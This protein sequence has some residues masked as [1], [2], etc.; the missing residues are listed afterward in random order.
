[1]AS[2][3]RTLA[4]LAFAG[5][6][7]LAAEPTL[8][9]ADYRTVA[10]AVTA[11]VRPTS[12]S[13]Q[14]GYLG[15]F[16][17]R[18][19]KGR[20]AVEAVQP[21]SPAD[22]AGL[23][24]G[25]V[26]TRVGDQPVKT[27][28]AF[29]EWL[30][31]RGA[32]ESVKLGVTRDDQPVEVTA[33]LAAT[34]RPMRLGTQQVV[35][36]AELADGKEGEGAKVERVIP[37]L[38]AAKAGLKA[39][40]HIIKL[41]GDDF[42]RTGRLA[43]LLYEK[44]PG[45][46][47]TVVVRR[48]DKEVELKVTLAYERTE[49]GPGGGRGRGGFIRAGGGEPPATPWKKDVFRLAVVPIEFTDIKHSAK[50]PTKEWEDALFSRDTYRK[51][52]SATGQPVHGSLNDYF[53]EQSGG[54]FRIEGKVFEWVAVGKKRADYSQGSGVTN[55]TAVMVEALDK[56]AAR[57]TKEAVKGFDGF[58]FLYAGDRVQTNAGA[59]YYPH[60]G[61]LGWQNN[62]YFYVLGPEGGPRMASIGVF[63]K[64]VARML[65][66]PDL[67]AQR[68]NAGS[69][70]LGVWCAL[71]DTFTNGRP[72]HLSAWAKEKMGW[73]KPAVIDPTVKQKLILAPIEDS[74]KECFKVLVRPDGSEYFLLENRKK[75]GFDA[76]LP[77]EGL[78]IW[79]VVND[80]PIL[81]ESHGVE[82]PTGPTVHLSA[83]PYPSPAS[84]AFTPDTTP[85]S[86]S[87]VGGGLP[88]HITDVR[89]LPDGRV[90]FHVGYEYR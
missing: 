86:V 7:T 43:D 64:E 46:V 36:G 4:C 78:L 38:P 42:S 63:A 62:R 49:G 17:Q 23:K 50:V 71:S 19:A 3:A 51:K 24:A 56:L 44:K 67:A 41:N 66:L 80:R 12:A 28:D 47:L 75:K 40:D 72:Q 61:S 90:T 81:E 88:V 34:S 76:D 6:I 85:S 58:L 52:S 27:P 87:P 21:G 79:R 13:G 39:G 22:A 57:D 59:V 9:L 15:A 37:D 48:E 14:T 35:F 55:K 25:D 45:D 20:L 65:G 54:A 10:T 33:V 84:N 11:Q 74:P 2:A 83:V 18:D 70:G 5:T 31:A 77:G 68:R 82:G 60:F 32:G 16:V 1:M 26:V 73:L 69:E 30:Q 29:R 8:E 53:A 89:R